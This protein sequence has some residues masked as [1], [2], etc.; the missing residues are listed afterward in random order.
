MSPTLN[1]VPSSTVIVVSP[2]A[3]SAWSTSE[4]VVCSYAVAFEH[5]DTPNALP[6][7]PGNLAAHSPLEP[8]PSS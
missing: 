3:T 5:I 1:S 7:V 2:A 4:V 6:Q 8:E